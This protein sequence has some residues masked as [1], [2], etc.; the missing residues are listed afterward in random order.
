MSATEWIPS[1]IL[2]SCASVEMLIFA[3]VSAISLK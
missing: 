1:S 3:P 2:M